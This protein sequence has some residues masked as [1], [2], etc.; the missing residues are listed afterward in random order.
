MARQWSYEP[1]TLLIL[2]RGYNDYAWFAELT[3]QGVYFVTR[4][5][6]NADYLVMEERELP[7]RRGLLRDQ[8]ICFYQQARDGQECYFR[9]IEFYDE[10]LGSN[11]TAAGFPRYLPWLNCDFGGTT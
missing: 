10:E 6:D 11:W 8:V 5:K 2:D 4:M 3:R 7:H 9:R 1:G